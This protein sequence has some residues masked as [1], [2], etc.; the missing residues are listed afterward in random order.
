MWIYLPVSLA[1]PYVCSSLW[2]LS[3]PEVVARH[4]Y[5]RPVDCWAVGVIMFILWVSTSNYESY[6]STKKGST[7]WAVYKTWITAL[8]D[9]WKGISRCDLHGFE[10]TSLPLSPYVCFP[11]CSLSGNPPF[12]D[13]TEEEN[14]DLHNRI[15]FCRIVAGDFEFDSPYWDDIS[16]AGT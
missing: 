5:G 16:P 15:I 13:E 2:C 6:S 11:F 12:Y 1:L 9:F 3:A 7:H 10:V 4:R 8:F 14:T